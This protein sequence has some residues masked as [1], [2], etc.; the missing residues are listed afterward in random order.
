MSE[1]LIERL[2]SEAGTQ[3]IDTFAVANLEELQQDYPDLLSELPGD[4]TRAL[5]FGITLPA[6]CL[7]GIVDRPT[8]IYFHHYRQLNYMLDRFATRVAIDL[9]Q[10]GF[11]ALAVPASQIISWKPMP[12]GHVSHKLLAHAA[13]LGWRGRNNLL[14]TPRHGARLRLVSVLTDL[15]TRAS[16]A[17]VEP[18]CGECRECIELCPAG[19]IKEGPELF[20]IGA[21]SGKLTQFQKLPGIGQRICGICVKACKPKQ[22]E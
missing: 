8:L 9:D 12:R 18:Q 1:G 16:N 21:C 3:G 17:P 7:T 6:A 5:V 10:A 19:A 20:D 2:K 13:G 15:S 22:P 4:F 11:S 14:V